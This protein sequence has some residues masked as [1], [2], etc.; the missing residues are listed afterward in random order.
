MQMAQVTNANTIPPTPTPA[1]VRTP[2]N[3]AP[4]VLSRSPRITP[5]AIAVAVTAARYTQPTSHDRSGGSLGQYKATKA[6]ADTQVHN[7]RGHDQ[8]L[9]HQLDGASARPTL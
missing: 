8:H 3:D 1:L 4:P 6:P 5:H 9:P 2:P 7:M